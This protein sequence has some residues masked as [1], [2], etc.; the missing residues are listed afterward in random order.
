MSL[1][2]CLCVPA[3]SPDI[4][5]TS[6]PARPHVNLVVGL[7][8]RVSNGVHTGYKP[9]P[10]ILYFV[11]I[12]YAPS[13]IPNRSLRAAC[14]FNM[15][16]SNANITS[17]TAAGKE[18]AV[19]APGN[20]DSAQSGASLSASTGAMSDDTRRRAEALTITMVP[21]LR[22]YRADDESTGGTAQTM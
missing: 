22:K 20:Q 2:S 5:L 14:L 7:R 19:G 15:S 13:P 9:I 6:P 4:L 11:I 21:L 1:P 17:N 10:L 18:K 16:S 12:S 8:R 3:H